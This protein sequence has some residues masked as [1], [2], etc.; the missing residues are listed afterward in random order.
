MGRILPF[1]NKRGEYRS[2]ILMKKIHINPSFLEQKVESQEDHQPS[3]SQQNSSEPFWFKFSPYQNAK[4]SPKLTASFTQHEKTPTSDYAEPAISSIKQ[5]QVQVS[6]VQ[7]NSP[8]VPHRSSLKSTQRKHLSETQSN[9]VISSEDE[10]QYLKNIQAVSNPE[11][12]SYYQSIAKKLVST[13]VNLPADDLNSQSEEQTKDLSVSK[14]SSV[15]PSEFT[16]QVKNI[17][18]TNSKSFDS[19]QSS[20]SSFAPVSYANVTNPD[21]ENDQEDKIAAKRKDLQDNFDKYKA[22]IHGVFAADGVLAK[23]FPNYTPRVGQIEFADFLL[24]GM[25][26]NQIMIIES[27]T[28]TGKT[29]SYL[30]PPILTNTP[31]AVATGTKALQD[32]VC[33]KDLPR[34]KEMLSLPQL[35]YLSL[36]GYQN[37][38]CRYL[39]S[40]VEN[41]NFLVEKEW[42][43]KKDVEGLAKLKQLVSDSDKEFFFINSVDNPLLGEIKFYLTDEQRNE[44]TCSSKR[45]RLMSAYCKHRGKKNSS[46]E[47][48]QCFIIKARQVARSRDVIA[49]NHSLLLSNILLRKLFAETGSSGSLP[50]TIPQ[51]LVIDEAHTFIDFARDFFTRE[52]SL[53]T[54]KNFFEDTLKTFNRSLEEEF[55]KANCKETFYFACKAFNNLFIVFNYLLP[56]QY[57]VKE[58]KYKSRL[59][60]SSIAHEALAINYILEKR[61]ESQ[62]SL[63]S[64][65]DSLFDEKSLSK[66]EKFEVDKI[67]RAEADPESYISD[68]LDQPEAK[69]RWARNS[70]ELMQR[71]EFIAKSL[72]SL[73]IDKGTIEADH[74]TKGNQNSFDLK[75]FAGYLSHLLSRKMSAVGFYTL[76]KEISEYFNHEDSCFEQNNNDL[77]QQDPFFRAVMVDF[78]L[79]LKYLSELVHYILDRIDKGTLKF[80]TI[81]ESEKKKDD[82]DPVEA[83][84]QIY[85][86][87]KEMYRFIT[88]FMTSDRD[89]NGDIQEQYVSW[90]E[91]AN[92]EKD[93]IVKLIV[94][95]VEIGPI[96]GP[97]LRK[98]HEEGTTLLFTSATL[99]VDNSFNRFIHD[100]GLEQ[101]EVTT[102]IIDSPFKYKDNSRYFTS[103]DFPDPNRRGRIS[104]CLDMIAPVIDATAGGVFYL[105]TSYVA[106]KEASQVFQERYG[107]KRQIFVQNTDTNNKLVEA[108]KQSGNGILL[109][110]AS[111]WEGVDVPG[112]ALSLV[113]LDKL[114]FGSFKD[115][116]STAQQDFIS[117][118]GGNPFMDLSVPDAVI[119][120]RQG[121]GRLIRQ[122]SDKGG[123]IILDPRLGDHASQ[124]YKYQF[125]NSMP[126]MTKAQSLQEMADFMRSLA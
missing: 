47:D 88:D 110:T 6:P 45:C 103:S 29:F 22:E 78:I 34:L 104:V 53:D 61:S 120:F 11:H 49:V 56:S 8:F 85:T 123:V 68:L 72:S 42:T 96:L 84:S 51:F 89:K 20:V 117:R 75:S 50:F 23:Q 77:P 67:L 24:E 14:S 55:F 92:K 70:S 60:S 105:T 17:T 71:C 112:K 10:Q 102:H 66:F 114:P 122:E 83:F 109:G 115:P 39:F 69:P 3:S 40:T 5:V 25:A 46:S 16:A 28:G 2:F 59:Y 119:R 87:L 124:N 98:I 4:K 54:L 48:S 57:S 62:S 13:V 80:R 82:F 64:Q 121:L 106:L 86:Q 100:L 65:V 35:K 44:V 33:T 101:E 26:K 111:F 108:F 76:E 93:R 15:A 37:Y 79:A 7:D 97:E 91:I 12:H 41:R 58:F 95:P 43:S 38:V 73:L 74:K 36:K 81:E 32:Q 9:P 21:E 99:T 116:L 125:L 30:I 18:P 118:H 94:A 27:G 107:N 19:V 31:V 52:Y 113:I 1:L 63:L 126:N 90:V